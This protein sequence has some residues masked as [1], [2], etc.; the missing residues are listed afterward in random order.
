MSIKTREELLAW[1]DRPV[2]IVG[3]GSAEGIAVLR[4]FDALAF[5]NIT[6][7]DSRSREVMRKAFRTTH[8]AYS[9]IQQDAIWDSLISYMDA[10][11]F[12]ADY[13]TGIEEDALIV[14]GQGWKLDASNRHV[15]EELFSD[16]VGRIATSMTEL[17][18]ALHDGVIAGVTG[19]NGKSTTVALIDH[20]LNEAGFDHKTAGNERSHRQFL[21]DFAQADWHGLALLEVSNRQLDQL[22]YISPK[23][24]AITSLTPDHL[25]EHGGFEQYAAVKR[26]LFA[27]QSADDIAIVNADSEQCLALVEGSSAQVVRCGL[28]SHSA[29]SV[30]WVGSELVADGIPTISGQSFSGT[31]AKREDL[32]L[33]GDHNLRN[34]AVGVAVLLAVGVNADVIAPALRT[35]QG[36]SL[37]LE[38]LGKFLGSRWYS[39]IKSTSPEA[40]LA[41]IAA[42]AESGSENGIVLIAGGDNKGLD[43]TEL[44]QAVTARAVSVALVP[45]S[46]SDQLGQ[47]IIEFGGTFQSVDDLD[48]GISWAV[49][50]A[51][52]GNVIIVSPAAAGFWTSQLQNRPSLRSR[53]RDLEHDKEKHTV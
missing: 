13:L 42:V 37:R 48:E 8:G 5:S 26:E 23:V 35:F 14:I 15:I 2:H 44:A 49:S 28:V 22:G 51:R 16:S 46:A 4:L 9:R 43:Y 17:Y 53:I 31:I 34:A 38:L 20:V 24:A 29:P 6:V 18:F 39:D 50:T 1:K 10:G 21:H 27:H 41:A 32:S 25:D 36:A 45:G 40:T 7:H 30:C 11:H 52:P 19:T 47:K 12:E 3:A 33:L